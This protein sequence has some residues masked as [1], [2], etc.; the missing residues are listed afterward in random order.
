MEGVRRGPHTTGYLA[1]SVASLWVNLGAS[2]SR[3]N[4]FFTGI[5]CRMLSALASHALERN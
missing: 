5:L 1:I 4:F 3:M 2:S